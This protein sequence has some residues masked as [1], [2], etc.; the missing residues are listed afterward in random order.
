[1]ACRTRLAASPK[2]SQPVTVRHSRNKPLNS[3]D[4]A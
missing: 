4:G 3:A 1:M 2:Y